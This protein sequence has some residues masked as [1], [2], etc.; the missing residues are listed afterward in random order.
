MTPEDGATERVDTVYQ[1]V[2]HLA[3]NRRGVALQGDPA[4]PSSLEI[5]ALH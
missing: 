3:A 2:R 1:M 5:S 4:R